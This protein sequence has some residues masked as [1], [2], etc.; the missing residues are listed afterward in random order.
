MRVDWLAVGV[1]AIS[2]LA[3][4][5]RGLVAGLFSVGGFVVGAVIGGRVARHFLP[6]GSS[7]PYLPLVALAGALAF[8]AVLQVLAGLVGSMARGSLLGLPPLRALDSAGG[9]V[10]GGAL[11]LA[12]VWV[13]GAVALQ[14]P[15][16][17][18]LRRAVQ[19]SEVLQRLNRI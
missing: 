19:R 13:V 6:G 1:V 18:S 9:A 12:L 3:G 7:S 15:G 5:R 11:G 8:A 10:L 2:A 16:Q 17:T 4:L 14:V